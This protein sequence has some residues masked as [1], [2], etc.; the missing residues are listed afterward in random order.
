MSEQNTPAYLKSLGISHICGSVLDAKKEFPEGTTL[1]DRLSYSNKTALSLAERYDG[2]YTPGFHVHPRYIRESCEEIEKMS[3]R[4]IRLIGELVPYMDEWSDYS[5]REFDEI[6][7]V[8]LMYNMIVNF[9]TIDN[10]QIDAMVKKLPKNIFVAAHP[11]EYEN[12][13]RYFERMK[14]S[15]NYS[16]DLSGTGLFRLG[17]LRHGI[18]VCGSERFLFGSDYPVCSPAIIIGELRLNPLYTDSERENIF[19]KNAKR[20]LGL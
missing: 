12:A 18:D 2:F 13:V 19:S 6:I 10:D 14:L 3:K 1:W 17:V 8:A 9:H 4:G 11:G 7:N 5:C 20:L 16:L 15:E